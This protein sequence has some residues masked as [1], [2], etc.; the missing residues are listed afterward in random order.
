MKKLISFVIL[1]VLS[2][3]AWAHFPGPPHPRPLPRPPGPIVRPRP[4]VGPGIIIVP[5][6]II[7][8]TIYMTVSNTIGDG[9]TISFTVNGN[10][11]SL[12]DGYN[13]DWNTT[14]EGFRIIFDNGNGEW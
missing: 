13:S 1:M 7:P 2:S 4:P 9:R 6:P 10:N 11:A 5:E 3:T 14:W 8:N 12:D